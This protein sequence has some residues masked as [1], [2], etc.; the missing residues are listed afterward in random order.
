MLPLILLPASPSVDGCN[1]QAAWRSE[2]EPMVFVWVFVLSRT[3]KRTGCC[4]LAPEVWL[5]TW[6]EEGGPRLSASLQPGDPLPR[7]NTSQMFRARPGAERE[8]E[9]AGSSKQRIESNEEIEQLKRKKTTGV[10]AASRPGPALAA[11]KGTRP[12]GSVVGVIV[13]GFVGH[14]PSSLLECQSLRASM[15]SPSRATTLRLRPGDFASFKILLISRRAL[16]P[17]CWV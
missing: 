11:Q 16:T 10:V 17:S 15:V 14:L 3:P 4:P 13:G 12:V 6:P 2:S 5:C 9:R 8:R 1:G 7:P